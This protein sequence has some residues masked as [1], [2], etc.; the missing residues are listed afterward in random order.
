MAPDEDED[1][2]EEDDDDG[3]VPDASP[4]LA[5]SPCANLGGD[6]GGDLE[7]PVIPDGARDGK[8][9]GLAAP[10]WS[11]SLFASRSTYL[12]SSSDN[13]DVAIVLQVDDTSRVVTR[14]VVV[15]E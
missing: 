13:L 7:P 6:L 3:G 5:V 12:F 14:F 8:W 4:P 1:E 10:S 9:L 11:A 15:V 2:E